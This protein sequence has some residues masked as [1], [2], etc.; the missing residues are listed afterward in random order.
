MRTFIA[1]DLDEALKKRLAALV[2]ELKPMAGNVRWV[3]LSGMHL[4]LKFLGEIPEEEVAGIS[5]VL[6]DIAGR[7]RPFPLLFKGTGA[8]PPGKR[9]PRVL[10][11]GAAPV[12]ALTSLQGDI[13][14]EMER[15][16][17]ERERRPF[18]PHLTL[19]R[20]KY[21]APFD[22]LI[23]SLKQHEERIFGELN[24]QSFIFFRSI[25]SPSGAQ[26]SALKEFRLR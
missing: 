20:V 11:V 1:I 9:Q 18:R 3:G 19:G 26:Y 24:V 5:S 17:Y 8:F 25:L 6:E 23:N 12:A 13:E 4:T 16:G 14:K 10:W 2:D 15:Q 22:S 7:H 21:P